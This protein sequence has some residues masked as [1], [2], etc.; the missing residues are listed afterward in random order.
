MFYPYITED[1]LNAALEFAEKF[2]EIKDEE[3][4]IKC[5]AK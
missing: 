2:T 1:L 5:Q 4:D 3:K